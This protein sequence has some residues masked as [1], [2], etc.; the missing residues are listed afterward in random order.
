M[1]SEGVDFPYSQ[2]P[3]KIIATEHPEGTCTQQTAQYNAG[4][5]G[6]N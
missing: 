1:N 5:Q 3:H 4:R 6:T 2:K